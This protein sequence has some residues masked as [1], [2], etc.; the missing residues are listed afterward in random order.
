MKIFGDGEY[1]YAEKTK[2]EDGSRKIFGEVY[3]IFFGR[4]Y[5]VLERLASPDGYLQKVGPSG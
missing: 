1:I 5:R 3:Y 4:C 2:N